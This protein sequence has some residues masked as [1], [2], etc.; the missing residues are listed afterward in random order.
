M[1]KSRKKQNPTAIVVGLGAVCMALLYSALLLSGSSKPVI[2]P[3]VAKENIEYWLYDAPRRVAGNVTL[4]YHEELGRLYQQRDYQMVWMDHYELSEAGQSLVRSLRHTASDEWKAYRY[5]ISKLQNEIARLSNEPAHATAIDVLLTDAYIDYA[6]QVLNNELLPNTGE[7]DHPSFRK[8]AAPPVT[9]VSSLDV[10]SLLSQSLEQG[11]LHSLIKE[12]APQHVGYERLTDELDRYQ[13]IADS[14]MWYP[15]DRITELQ[16]GQANAQVPRLRW[17]LKAYGDFEEG[18]LAWLMPKPNDPS[19][20]P[21][22]LEQNYRLGDSNPA[23]VFDEQTAQ[24]LKRFQQRN[25]LAQTGSVDEA[26]L[27][28]LNVPPYQIAQRIALNMKRWRY[29]PKS[30][31]ERYI[32]VNMANFRL[33]L[34]ERGES[35][36]NMKVIIGREARRTP[37]LA[38]TISTVVLAPEWNVPH[39]IAMRDIIPH[40]KQDPRYLANNNFKVYEGWQMP[41]VEVP[42]AQLDFEGF[43]SRINTYR[44]VQEPGEDNSLGHVKFVFPNDKSIYLHDTNHKEL[45]SRD[46]R[47]LSS[48]CIRVE[49]PI[50][51]ATALLSRQNWNRKLVESTIERARPRPIQLQDPIPVYLMYWTTWVDEQ[52]HFQMRDDVYKRDLIDSERHKLESIIL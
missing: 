30:M 44:F 4:Q 31:G 25:G 36:L 2:P 34:I 22:L 38:E 13:T 24:A 49:K 40:A 26:T 48:G 15:F 18:K 8:V 10:I 37:V 29:L 6:Q 20:D 21:L 27:A 33:D 28:R 45:F 51:L 17:M 47:A 42:L 12:M 46:M 7:L 1:E 35:T 41:A 3:L 14:G 43:N 39:R 23:Y 5:R 50:E 19:A 32:L 9:R 16:Q 52:G 11:K